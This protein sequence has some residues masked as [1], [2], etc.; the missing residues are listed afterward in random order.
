[1]GFIP[2]SIGNLWRLNLVSIELQGN[3]NHKF[4]YNGKEK[5]EESGL[6]WSDYG[7]RMYDAQLGRWHV[8]DPVASKYSEYSPYSFVLNNPLKFIDSDGNTVTDPNG[9]II[10]TVTEKNTLVPTGR[11]R[12]GTDSKGSYTAYE[13]FYGDKGKILTD[14]G[15]E[16]EAYRATEGGNAKLYEVKR[17]NGSNEISAPVSLERTGDCSRD[18]TGNVV[19][20]EELN[21]S[22]LDFDE[23]IQNDDDYRTLSSGKEPKAGDVGAYKNKAGQSVHFEKYMDSNTV[24]SKGGT[25]KDPGLTKPHTKANYMDKKYSVLRKESPHMVVKENNG[26]YQASKTGTKA[27][28]IKEVSN[29]QFEKSDKK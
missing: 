2:L 17:Y 27:S 22:T 15:T 16:I 29:E 11:T 1:M 23:T 7:A 5:Q 3:P 24:N 19:G 18:C 26:S 13:V 28:G 20:G 14:K 25:A 10:F 12:E 9:K 21:M 4:Q 6:N 8:I